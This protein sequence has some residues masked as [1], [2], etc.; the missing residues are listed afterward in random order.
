MDNA[1]GPFV[2]ESD[3]D[4]PR[5]IFTPRDRRFLG[6]VLEEDLEKNAERQK[7]Y[8]LRERI[9]HALQDLRYLDKFRTRDLAQVA[10]KAGLNNN[11]DEMTSEQQRVLQSTWE[12]L[13]LLREIHGPDPFEEML[14][15]EIETQAKLDHY[16]QTGEY[17]EYDVEINIEQTGSMSMNELAEHVKS[18]FLPS[19]GASEVLHLHQES[20]DFDEM[21]F[22][23]G[24]S[25][26]YEPEDPELMS[27]VLEIMEELA[28]DR[29]RADWD[30]VVETAVERFDSDE[31]AVK[32]AIQD[33]LFS[34]KCYE[35]EGGILKPI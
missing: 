24:S 14:A 19:P 9:F 25:S 2:K 31:E 26:S 29:K 11:T 16:E 28:E 30:R 5:G 3:F 32:T 21:N 4:R 18:E 20:N 23:G 35:P 34:G 1:I 33:A 10:E 17:G 8:Q 7:R 6:K 27:Q 13:G 15:R 12:I 22:S